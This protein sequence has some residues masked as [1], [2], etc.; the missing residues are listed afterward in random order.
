M[1]KIYSRDNCMTLVF[2]SDGSK[3]GRGFEAFYNSTDNNVTK[4]DSSS[5]CRYV[6]CDLWTV[7]ER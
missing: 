3:R 6:L 4:L 5:N 7:F 2:K 1:P